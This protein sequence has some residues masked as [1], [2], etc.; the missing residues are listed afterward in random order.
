M[1]GSKPLT[2]YIYIHTLHYITHYI[3]LHYITLPY[4]T[5]HYH[6]YIH[7]IT[8]HYIHTDIHTYTH[9][10]IHTSMHAYIHTY[11]H[12]YIPTYLHTY[13]HIYDMIWYDIWIC[14]SNVCFVSV[15][16]A[17]SSTHFKWQRIPWSSST[18]GGQLH[19]QRIH[20]SSWELFGGFAGFS[21]RL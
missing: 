21:I 19:I 16:D 1:M 20:R 6:T 14:G 12:T 11:L 9:T 3:T 18:C 10:Y 5:L 2:I 7:Y 17:H 4:I 13:I 8:L 15:L